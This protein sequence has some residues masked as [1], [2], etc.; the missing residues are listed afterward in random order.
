MAYI[1]ENC[2]NTGQ[3]VSEIATNVQK[4][5]THFSTEITTEVD[6]NRSNPMSNWNGNI[7]SIKS[8]EGGCSKFC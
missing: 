1:A 3:N 4:S 5:P 2:H 8:K 6:T 7:Q